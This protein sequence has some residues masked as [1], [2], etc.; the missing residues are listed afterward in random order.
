MRNILLEMD[1]QLFIKDVNLPNKER[2]RDSLIMEDIVIF[3]RGLLT[4]QLQYINN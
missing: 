2:L 1:E 3:N 4:R